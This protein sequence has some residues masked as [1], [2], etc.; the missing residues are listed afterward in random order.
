MYVH[1]KMEMNTMS[2]QKPY[3]LAYSSFICNS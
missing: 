2:I 3:I 1:I